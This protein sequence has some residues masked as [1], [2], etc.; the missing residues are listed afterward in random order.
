VAEAAWGPETTVDETLCGA[1]KTLFLYP[2]VTLRFFYPFLLAPYPLGQQFWLHFKVLCLAGLI[3]LWRQTFREGV[4]VLFLLVY[5][6]LV[7][8]TTIFEH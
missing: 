2:A 5:C 4:G 3:V 6:P 7:F 1:A 8:N